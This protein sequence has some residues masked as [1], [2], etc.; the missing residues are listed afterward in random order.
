MLN[1]EDETSRAAEEK[2]WDSFDPDDDPFDA[3]DF[4]EPE[5]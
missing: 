2:D 4:D 5:E 1:G 3:G